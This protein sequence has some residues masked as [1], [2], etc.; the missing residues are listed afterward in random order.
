MILKFYDYLSSKSWQCEDGSYIHPNFKKLDSI[1]ENFREFVEY[2]FKVG[3]KVAKSGCQPHLF[4]LLDL[5]DI[6]GYFTKSLKSSLS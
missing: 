4:Q 5:L 1:F 6:N 3:T 2:F